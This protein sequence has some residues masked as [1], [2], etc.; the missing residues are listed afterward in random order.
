ME[1]KKSYQP[2]FAQ[3]V[4]FAPCEEISV[5][6]GKDGLWWN[7]SDAWW[8]DKSD[9]SVV[10]GT[11]GVQDEDGNSWTYDGTIHKSS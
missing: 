11:L 4:I 2:P 6:Y 10:M 8:G 7:A 9:A 3:T 5:F 1:N